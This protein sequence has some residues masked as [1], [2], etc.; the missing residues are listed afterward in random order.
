MTY[1]I[2]SPDGISI[3]WDHQFPTSRLAWECYKR[4]AKRYE[5]QGYYSSN[6]RRIPLNELKRNCQLKK[7]QNEK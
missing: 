7:Q 6:F 4:W 5:K 3:S 2:L 1:D